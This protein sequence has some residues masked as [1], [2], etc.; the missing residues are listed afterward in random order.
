VAA[1]AIQTYEKVSFDH[2]SPMTANQWRVGLA[3]ATNVGSRVQCID[4]TWKFYAAGQGIRLENGELEIVG[5][6]ITKDSAVSLTA[7]FVQTNSYKG[8]LKVNGLDLSGLNAGVN[9]FSAPGGAF[10]GIIRNS[11]LPSGWSG[12]LSGTDPTPGCRVEMHNCDD[13]NTN[14]RMWVQE[15]A[16]SIKSETVVTRTGGAMD[17]TTALAWKMETSADAEFPTLVLA[18]PELAIWN[19]TTGVAK[20]VTLHVLTD[21]VTLKDDE[22]WLEVTYL[23]TSGAPLGSVVTDRK[24]GLLTA[25]QV[26][27]ASSAA[28]T[29]T[30]IASPVMQK[31]SVTVTPQKKGYM[32][33]RAMFV[34]PGSTMYVCYS[35]EIS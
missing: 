3:G 27:D 34:K 8:S 2:V 6:S 22:A 33:L 24:A 5:G 14:Y 9:I 1:A 4:C 20:T 19:D 35:P 12:K 10:K 11:K 25:A 32:I 29:T 17:G 26:Q 30:G 21:G 7:L 31:L 13:G 28:W 15:Y 23:G 16:G 18:S